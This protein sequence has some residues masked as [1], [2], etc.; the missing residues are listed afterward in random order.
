MVDFGRKFSSTS[1]CPRF[2]GGSVA[3]YFPLLVLVRTGRRGKPKGLLSVTRCAVDEAA[4][5]LRIR[6]SHQNVR[7]MPCRS[8]PNS[9]QIS[10][11]PGLFSRLRAAGP[12]C[13]R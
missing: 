2:E 6:Q 1:H 10:V 9:R 12:V 7:T 13:F 11:L 8:L 5:S 4:I 3:Y